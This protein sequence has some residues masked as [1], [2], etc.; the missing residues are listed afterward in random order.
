MKLPATGGFILFGDR[1]IVM[2]SFFWLVI[3]SGCMN[4][5]LFG[6]GIIHRVTQ[7]E[8]VKQ[9][10]EIDGQL[11]LATESGAYRVVAGEISPVLTGE[12]VY[13]IAAVAGQVW[14]GTHQGL[15]RVDG[16]ETGLLFEEAL[17]TLVVTALYPDGEDV[18][19]GTQYGL[20]LAR[21]SSLEPRIRGRV[22]AI[23]EIGG[24]I[25]VGTDRNAYRLSKNG[26][27]RQVLPGT[28]TVADVV[29]ILDASGHVR[30]VWLVT[31][32][33]GLL[34]GACYRVLLDGGEEVS[35]PTQFF[36]EDS[37]ISV[38]D[39]DGEPWFATTRGVFRL[40]NERPERVEFEI[41]EIDGGKRRF[42]LSEPINT[43][44]K[45]DGVLW[46]GTLQ[47]AYRSSGEF[48]VPIPA[49]GESLNV[50][51]FC[52]LAGGIWLRSLKG[53]YRYDEDVRLTADIGF[54]NSRYLSVKGLRYDLGGKDPYGSDSSG[55]RLIAE[56]DRARFRER[57]RNEDF[58]L[59]QASSMFPSWLQ[60]FHVALRDDEGNVQI[61]ERRAVFVPI[62][63]LVLL[64]VLVG[65]VVVV[66]V[67]W[68]LRKK[69]KVDTLTGLWD[70]R[71]VEPE[72]SQI[73]EE[74]RSRGECVGVILM[75]IDLFKNINTKYGHPGGDAVL[76]ALGDFLKSSVRRG[77]DKKNA[78]VPD[79]PCRWGGEE[80]L[81]LLRGLTKDQ[82]V[83]RAEALRVGIEALCPEVKR[84]GVLEKVKV[85][86][87]VC[88][89]VSPDH[90]ETLPELHSAA[91]TTLVAAKTRGERNLVHVAEKGM[92][93]S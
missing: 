74:H 41:L 47:R 60:T 90:G 16:D 59:E 53:A 3:L 17:G 39:V 52:F 27:P 51:E 84:G 23:E 73:V 49:L 92:S 22:H 32:G 24:D 83:S 91:S 6:E 40:N 61:E 93:D 88:V 28:V 42:D 36:P 1:K 13:S 10:T 7:Q 69:S 46:V 20:Y 57:L 8:E 76:K 15:H 33:K 64:L 71:R 14:A 89:A 77:D 72:I 11:W 82:A 31:L 50:K 55:I 85:T 70:R 58:P 29:P 63:F 34:Y 5:A 12:P 30:E 66:L 78:R 86:V 81:V 75:D 2:K 38:A 54:W 80:F 4:A 62:V 35:T 19:V 37:V 43:L 79:I 18:W 26:D 25:W 48:L 65:L 9:I 87:T 44:A 56:V 21:S 45:I 68:R 67:N